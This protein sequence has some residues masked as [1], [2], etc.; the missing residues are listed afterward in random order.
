M[1]AFL[2]PGQKKNAAFGI[3]FDTDRD[4]VSVAEV[5]QGEKQSNLQ[6]QRNRLPVTR[7]HREILYLLERHS[8]TVLV[9]ETGCGKTTQVP[10]MLLEAGW[11]AGELVQTMT[12][13][14]Y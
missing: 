3:S 2:K 7:Y 11:A 13:T 8:C 9:G 1:G 12:D 4:A 10:Q 5:V 14:S 6:R